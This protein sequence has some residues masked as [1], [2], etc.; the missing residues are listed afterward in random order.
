MTKKPYITAR[1]ADGQYRRIDCE[2]YED[3]YDKLSFMLSHNDRWREI[4]VWSHDRD[5][6]AEWVKVYQEPSDAIED[7]RIIVQDMIR[8]AI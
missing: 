4:R 7:L 5:G 6:R 8:E 2:D 1:Q 3:A